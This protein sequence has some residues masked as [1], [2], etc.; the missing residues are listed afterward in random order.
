[1]HPGSSLLVPPHCSSNRCPCHFAAAGVAGVG[2]VATVAVGVAHSVAAVHNIRFHTQA[3]AAAAVVAVADSTAVVAVLGWRTCATMDCNRNGKQEGKH[4]RAVSGHS[5]SVMRFLLSFCRCPAIRLSGC[6]AHLPI[7]KDPIAE[8]GSNS[9]RRRY[10][11]EYLKFFQAWWNSSRH[12]F[13]QSLQL[14]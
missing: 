7:I 3:P 12:L 10:L 9:A 5:M 6:C 11:K 2:I 4:G 14:H 8:T 13:S 1:M